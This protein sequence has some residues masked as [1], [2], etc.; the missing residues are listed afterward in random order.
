[1][2]SHAVLVKLDY[3]VGIYGG[4]EIWPLSDPS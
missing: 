4:I 2:A 3:S 1:M